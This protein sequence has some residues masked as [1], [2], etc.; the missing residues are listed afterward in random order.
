[1]KTEELKTLLERY[2]RGE[3]TLP[4]EQQLK[5]FFQQNDVPETLKSDRETFLFLSALP[6]QEA[7]LPAGMEER[8]SASIRRWEADD[9]QQPHLKVVRP[10][11]RPKAIGSPTLRKMKW[12]TGIAAAVL[13]AAGAG[14]HLQKAA[15]QPRDTFDNPQL[16]YAEAERALQ[17]FAT[18]LDKGQSHVSKAESQT[19]RL[20][21]Q[22]EKCCN[23]LADNPQTVNRNLK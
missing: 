1:M 11:S 13:I 18:A 7:P 2:Y 19:L 9:A 5:S 6:Q 21:E 17:L 3:T 14:L 20:R 8:L 16:A 15:G 4:E 10:T 22:L 23:A 12:Y